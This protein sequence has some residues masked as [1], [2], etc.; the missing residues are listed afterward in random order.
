[1]IRYFLILVMLSVPAAGL[2][3]QAPAP[4]K[5]QQ[6]TVILVGGT[7]HIGNG[8]VIEDALLVMKKG[9][10]A[11][12]GSR[13]EVTYKEEAI[14]MDVTGQHIYPGLIL[15]ASNLGLVE[16]GSVRASVDTRETGELN[17]N[18]RSIVAYDSDS[19][20]IPA[21]RS[22]GVLMAQVVPGGGLVSGTSS[23]VQL[24]AWDWEEAALRMDNGMHMRWPRKNNAR[25]GQIN[26]NPR[27]DKQVKKIR[28]LFTDAARYGEAPRQ[29][30]S[31]ARLQSM[32]GLF[33]GSMR[34]YIRAGEPATIIESVR[35][36]QNFGVQKIT[37]TQ[38]G[39]EVWQVK[40]FLKDNDVS[41]ILSE[42]HTLPS[43]THQDVWGPC[44][45]PAQL[46]REGIPVALSVSWLPRSINY[47]FLAGT[48]AAF[49]LQKEEALQLITKIPAEI[50]GVDD[51][52]GTLEAGKHANLII[53]EG[54]ILDMQT[55]NITHAFISG[56][57]INL[58]N[59]HK[60]LYRKYKKRYGQ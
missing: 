46:Y 27:Y 5:A 42:I 32:Q 20:L 39:E 23:I 11:E 22:N 52:T 56:R 4:A 40:D 9:R 54:D 53:S 28:K 45:L 30:Q 49:G 48:A 8:R 50:L 2:Q 41:V 3:A 31:N 17:P 38:A 21:L 15:P 12:I 37:L 29:A 51:V 26:R 34:L 10:I 47:A 36:A 59:H 25:D 18:V 16:I 7:A 13:D 1:M 57:M 24:D 60:K 35:F 14:V 33:D 43:A 6:Q 19:R 44:K 58:D 55:N